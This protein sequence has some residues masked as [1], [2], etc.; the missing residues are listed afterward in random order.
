[1]SNIFRVICRLNAIPIQGI[2]VDIER[3]YLQAMHP[4]KDWYLEYIKRLQNSTEKKVQL[5]HGQK[6]QKD[7][8]VLAMAGHAHVRHTLIVNASETGGKD[9]RLH[10]CLCH[11]CNCGHRVLQ[12]VRLGEP[13]KVYGNLG[14]ISHNCI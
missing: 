10:A 5:E 3:K 1:M 14:V 9:R 12:G 4:T 2:S 8:C 13:G 7:T 11:G 6:T